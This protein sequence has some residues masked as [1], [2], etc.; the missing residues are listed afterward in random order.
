MGQNGKDGAGFF[1]KLYGNRMRRRVHELGHRK[2]KDDIKKSFS[3]VD[4]R[5]GSR[6]LEG[7]LA[8]PFLGLLQT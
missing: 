3:S 8:S 7:P 5:Y 1:L 2:F 6:G 4:V